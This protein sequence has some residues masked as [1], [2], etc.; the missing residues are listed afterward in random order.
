VW[1]CS[2]KIVRTFSSP[3]SS[4]PASQCFFALD[5]RARFLF[6][7][8]SSFSSVDSLVVSFLSFLLGCILFFFPVVHNALRTFA[9][10][11]LL[12]EVP[13]YHSSAPVPPT[14]VECM[15]QFIFSSRHYSSFGLSEMVIQIL[16]HP[17]NLHLG[18]TCFVFTEAVFLT[19]MFTLSLH[20]MLL[21]S[22]PL[23]SVLVFH[24]RK[25]GLSVP[26]LLFSPVPPR[27]FKVR[28]RIFSSAFFPEWSFLG[29]SF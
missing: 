19:P 5:N 16:F 20:F 17:L 2:S 18:S 13:L 4:P 12:G 14:F 21:Q 1:N 24:R 22:M 25:S 29:W 23:L 6:R 3:C 15:R 28:A 10:I 7:R 9:P 11:P 27:T 26:P 8:Y